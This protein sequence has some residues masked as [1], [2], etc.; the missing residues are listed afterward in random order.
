MTATASTEAI[1]GLPPGPTIR[2]G[3]QLFAFLHDP[4]PTMRAARERYGGLFT[5]K[6]AEFTLVIVS[7]PKHIREVFTGPADVMLA[8]RANA[9]LG[10]MVG[11]RSLLLLDGAE[12]LKE[13]RLLLPPFHG[14]RMK[15]Y[16]RIIERATRR[17]IE[18]WPR[19]RAFELMPSMREITLEVIMRAVLGVSAGERYE[20]LAARIRRLLTPYAS[21]ARL[22]LSMFRTDEVLERRFA[23]QHADVDELIYAEIADRRADPR[24]HEREDILSMLVT[25][26]DADGDGLDDEALHDEVMTLLVAGHETTAT[27][28]GWTFERLVRNDDVMAKL[29]EEVDRGEHAYL[30]AVIK[31]SLRARPVVPNVGRILARPYVI[32]GY[33]LPAGT[34][35]T[36]SIALTHNADDVYD[37]AQEFRPER[38]LGDG[39]PGT[40]EW[41]PFGGGPRRCIGAS[42]ALFEMRVVVR[43]ILASGVRFRADRPEP[44]GVFR[45]GVSLVPERGARVVRVA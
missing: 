23:E 21:R 6:L 13:R 44:E 7:D 39:A 2:P 8:G 38:F 16:E 27:G 12:H 9:P 29:V 20:E 1:K 19:K 17:E 10:P 36:P 32:G 31:E 4:A 42:F 45:Q 35:V 28:L 25:A 30:D 15:A 22:V 3:P 14:A 33:E 43:T 18:E 37:E 5:L 41:L 40:Y 11:E 34:Q 24:V 26:R